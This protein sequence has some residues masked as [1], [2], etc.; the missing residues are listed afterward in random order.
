MGVNFDMIILYEHNEINI[1]S[2][3]CK[4]TILLT[5]GTDKMLLKDRKKDILDI[6]YEK[7]RIS[8][9]ELAKTLFVSEMTI[10]RDLSEL[11]KKGVLKR[12]RGGAVLTAMNGDMPISQRFFVD[13]NEKKELGR[14]AVKFLEDNLT[15][16]IDSS[17]TCQYIIPYIS[18]F[19]N[20]TL[21]T[22]S[23]NA[24]LIA[25]KSQIQC[26][27]IGGK[28]Y[29]QDMCFIG[30]IAEQYAEQFN[31]DVAFF[32][33]LGMSE[34]GIISD[35]DIEQTMIRKI[36]MN[37]S[38]KNIFLFEKSKLNKKYFYTLCYKND[39]DEILISN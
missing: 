8:V 4:R 27:L 36:V 21:I 10:R 39:V 12:Y 16:Y 31:V 19:K 3:C 1:C 2:K 37:H 18:R 33:S 28:Y 13:E 26:I 22:N 17:S 11:E 15:I 35:P 29:G 20:I 38:K 7:G 23:V 14:Q 6:L 34:D 24:L 32:S 25:S 30:S 9:S 5:K